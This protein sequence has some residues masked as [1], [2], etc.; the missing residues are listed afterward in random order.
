MSYARKDHCDAP[1]AAGGGSDVGVC[2]EHALAEVRILARPLMP[3][4]LSVKPLMQ[5]SHR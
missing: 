4:S 2:Q 1:V 3:L 5:F